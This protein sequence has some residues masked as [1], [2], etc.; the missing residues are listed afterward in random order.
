M[1]TA[2]DY[3]LNPK[4][5]VAG[6]ESYTL[7]A[8]FEATLAANPDGPAVFEGGRWRN[9]REWGQ[10]A[11]AL[12]RALQELGVAK[13]EVVALHLPNC[14]EYLTTHVA[15]SSIGAVMF[16]LHMAYGE[17]E[18]KVLLERCA[19]AV[20][21]LPATYGKRDLVETGRK[22]LAELPALRHVIVV[23]AT[24][25]Q[26]TEQVH[27]LTEL[28]QRWRGS[29]LLP[30]QISPDDPFFLL[31]SS[32]TTSLR[33]KICMHSHA[34]LLSNAAAVS[35]ESQAHPDDTLVSA[36]PFTHLFGLLSIHLSLFNKGKQALLGGWNTENFLELVATAG[37]TVAF[38][39][40]A[41]LRDACIYQDT[42]PEAPRIK[43]R[44]VR[45][46][47]AGVPAQLVADVRR[48]LGAKVTVQW[49]MSEIGAGT[50]TRPNDP[51][52][53]AS[54]SIGSPI[55]GAE[56][57]VVGEDGSEVA[58]GETGELWYRSLHMFRGYLG[59]LEVT[60]QAVTPDGWLKTGDLTNRNEDGTLA[61]RGRR[62]EF[63]NRGG[64]KFSAVEVE[65]L[66]IDL[67]ALNQFAIIAREDA[68]LG[69]R[70]LLVASIRPG[71]TV[72]LKDVTAHLALKGL[73][74]YKW[75]E[76]LIIVEELPA[77]P[78]GKI[79]R[80]RLAQLLESQN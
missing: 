35:A 45:T 10:E 21:V 80:V 11:T 28:A 65:S 56:V 41:Q 9:W 1:I 73:A 5:G 25:G 42:H 17:H 68:R 34:G 48:V 30:V 22:L 44:E 8:V 55:P 13:G 50:F 64:L 15:V 46:G 33:P 40:P 36:S 32:G 16:P 43:L 24:D 29:S 63:I 14:W 59:D 51:P 23:G 77:T 60:Q 47:G 69:Q 53:T 4:E 79:A 38:A 31:A 58:F 66:L 76:E 27:S 70:S 19:A 54:H 72:N 49:G 74:R 57:K 7:P 78:T 67:S 71:Y 26:Q 6:L 12:G 75:P 52:E 37:A 20:L 62:T 61:Y 3:F 39:V 2:Q 18:L